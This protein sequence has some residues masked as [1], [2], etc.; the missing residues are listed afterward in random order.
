MTR[1]RR[2]TED[3]LGELAV[4]LAGIALV[5]VVWL[6]WMAPRLVHIQMPGH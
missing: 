4:G 2:K 3:R 6:Y 1:R 5:L